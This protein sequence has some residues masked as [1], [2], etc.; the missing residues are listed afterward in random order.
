MALRYGFSY[1]KKRIILILGK[2][3]DTPFLREFCP[4]ILMF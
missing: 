4:Q 2:W 1:K 3:P